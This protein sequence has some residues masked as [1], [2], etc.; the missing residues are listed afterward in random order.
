LEDSG[1]E[2]ADIRSLQLL[3]SDEAISNFGSQ[4][5]QSGFLG[6]ENLKRQLLGCSKADVRKNLSDLESAD[7]SV[8]ALDSLLLSESVS[9]ESEDALLKFVLKLGRGYRDLLR[10]IQVVFLSEDGLSLLEEIP[11]E[12]LWYFIA[13][14]I[15]HLLDSGIISD[16]PGIFA[17]FRGKGF[18]I[19]WRGS[20][21]GFGAKELHHRC[22]GHANT[23]TLIV[24]TKGNSF[25]AFTPVKWKSLTWVVKAGDSLKSFPF[26]L[27]NPHSVP[28]RTFALK[29]DKKHRAIYCCSDRASRLKL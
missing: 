19:V 9:V 25:G 5:L 26:T 29:A 1:I 18:G 12:S 22:D 27:K 3:L 23:L 21:D 15:A 24:D 7:L 17:E 13:E 8:E 6:K 4:L 10:H 11:P 14:R 16:F 20:R 2:A 28:A